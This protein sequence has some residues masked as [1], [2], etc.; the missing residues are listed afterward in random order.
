[1]KKK[2]YGTYTS[3]DGRFNG[4]SM[5]GLTGGCIGGAG[6]LTHGEKN[7]AKVDEYGKQAFEKKIL[8]ATAVLDV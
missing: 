4:R 2:D 5:G 7:K 1:M 8:D 6:V 3:T